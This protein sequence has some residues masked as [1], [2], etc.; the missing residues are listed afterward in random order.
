MQR[1]ET[2]QIVFRIDEDPDA[3]IT[4]NESVTCVGKFLGHE[5]AKVPDDNEPVAFTLA[6]TFA[7][8]NATEPNRW[9]FT[10]SAADS[11]AVAAGVYMVEARIPLVNGYVHKPFPVIFNL[12]NSVSG[13]GA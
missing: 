8:A 4:G 1:G 12:I 6:P 5:S 10:L 7:A 2:F 9:Y 13:N 11:F 3:V